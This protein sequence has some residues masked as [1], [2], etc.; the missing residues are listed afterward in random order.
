MTGKSVS[1]NFNTEIKENIAKNI[2]KNC[3]IKFHLGVWVRKGKSGKR[4]ALFLFYSSFF[5]TG[6]KVLPSELLI[7]EKCSVGTTVP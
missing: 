3:L 2:V 4:T 6:I 5:P 1:L 7:K